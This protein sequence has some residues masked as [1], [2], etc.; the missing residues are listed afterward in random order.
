MTHTAWEAA[1]QE[2]IRRIEALDCVTG[3][4]VLLRKEELN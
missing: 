4:I 3:K 2:A 1:V